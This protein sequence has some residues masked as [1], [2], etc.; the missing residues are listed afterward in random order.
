[1]VLKVRRIVESRLLYLSRGEKRRGGLKRRKERG[2]RMPHGTKRRSGK[3][4]GREVNAP[5]KLLIEDGFQRVRVRAGLELL[6]HIPHVEGLRRLLEQLGALSGEGVDRVF[7]NSLD[8]GGLQGDESVHQGSGVV[9]GRCHVAVCV[10]AKG[11]GMVGLGHG[12][13]YVL[14]EPEVAILGHEVLG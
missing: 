7:V 10:L 14:V 5:V 13:N 11:Q 1:M 6:A 2:E 8:D 3:A 9:N 12:P 4:E